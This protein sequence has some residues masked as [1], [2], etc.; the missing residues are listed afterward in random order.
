VNHETDVRAWLEYAEANRRSVRNAMAAADYRDVAFHC[1]Q[2]V[3]KL[4]KA[5]IVQ[6]TSQRP[7]YEH[8][9]W[10]LWQHIS[11]IACPPEVE[12]A[13]AA[14][15]PHYF[16]SRYPGVG[17]EYDLTAAQELVERWSAYG[18]GLR[19]PRTYQPN[20]SLPGI[21]RTIRPDRAGLALWLVCL[22]N[23]LF[24]Q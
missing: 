16:L 19:G 5:V 20:S 8:N 24:A 18:N 12:E 17:I 7:P 1:Q 11:G 13:L 21:R 15:N 3:E 6:Q 10:K 4:L 14:L 22:R 2:A 9:L 23:S